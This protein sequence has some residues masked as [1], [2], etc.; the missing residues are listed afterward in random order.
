MTRFSVGFI[1]IVTLLALLVPPS[2]ARAQDFGGATR[3]DQSVSLTPAKFASELRQLNAR[4][5]SKN[6]STEQL[7]NAR[8]SIPETWE[9]DAPERH[10]SI[11]SRQL[12]S[13]LR[14]AETNPALRTEQLEAARA[15][16]SDLH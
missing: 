15:W 9:I 14:I 10:Y 4:L 8:A 16:L 11:P 2:S 3:T 12:I 1:F 7:A 6:I 5:D 13:M